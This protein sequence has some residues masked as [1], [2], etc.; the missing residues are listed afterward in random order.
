MVRDE[1][2]S[3]ATCVDFGLNTQGHYAA[4]QDAVREGLTAY[5]LDRVLG[6]GR[7]IT[8]LVAF[9][10][11]YHRPQAVQFST[12]YDLMPSDSTIAHQTLKDKSR[13][14]F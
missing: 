2:P 9:A 8:T 1:W 4:M 12:S 5:E 7:A 13:L 11:H 6:N 14:N 10:T 3:R